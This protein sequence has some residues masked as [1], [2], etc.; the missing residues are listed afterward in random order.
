MGWLCWGAS[1]ESSFRNSG[2]RRHCAS[3]GAVR[4]CKNRYWPA[5]LLG[6]VALP[7]STTRADTSEPAAAE[8]QPQY[9]VMPMASKGSDRRL[10]RRLSLQ[11]QP[12]YDRRNTGPSAVLAISGGV[13]IFVGSDV[14]R[15]T[16]RPGGSF[17]FLGGVDFGYGVLELDVGY[18][19]VPIQAPGIPREPLQRVH[20]GFGGRLQVPNASRVIPYI[21][22][23]FAAQ[24]WK[25]DTRTGCSLIACSTGDGFRFA[26][27]LSFRTGIAISLCRSTALDIG[28]GY[29]LSFRGNDVFTK[30]RQWIEPTVGFR[31][32]L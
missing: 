13:P 30:T 3:V 25:L 22:A 14:D 29:N 19:G 21:S 20:F 17:A 9:G 1:R 32:W 16:V 27:G 31:F 2:K 15:D 18:M 10:E 26:P 7:A 11:G 12:K 8:A 28:L 4:V 6:L 23:G 24:W 5:V